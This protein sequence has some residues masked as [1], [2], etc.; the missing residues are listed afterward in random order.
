MAAPAS[1]CPA[2][3]GG[4]F[5]GWA[6]W[7]GGGQGRTVPRVG[8]QGLPSMSLSDDRPCEFRGLPAPRP[9]HSPQT[10]AKYPRLAAISGDSR[11]RRCP[12]LPGP[13]R[14]GA[15][16]R[17][18]ALGSEHG[19][20]GRRSAA[21]AGPLRPAHPLPHAVPRPP[22]RARHCRP[23]RDPRPRRIGTSGA[24]CC[25]TRPTHGRAIGR[26]Q[27]CVP[28]WCRLDGGPTPEELADRYGRL[29][30]LGPGLGRSG[31]PGPSRPGFYRVKPGAALVCRVNCGLPQSAAKR[32]C[33]AADCGKSPTP[34]DR[35]RRRAHRART[36]RRN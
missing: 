36:D 13:A 15:Q 11:T 32:H 35:P 9:R 21:G 4:R 22:R 2:D 14:L 31:L 30:R 12:A 18:Q 28:A 34:E 26:S 20:P 25:P 3:D 29:C 24:H 1:L 19:S 17:Y 27:P 7:A 6:G 8:G 10:A 16:R 23:Q 5:R 33:L